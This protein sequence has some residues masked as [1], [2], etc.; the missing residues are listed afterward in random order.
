VQHDVPVK[1]LALDRSN[2]AWSDHC[3]ADCWVLAVV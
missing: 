1:N 3:S 2:A